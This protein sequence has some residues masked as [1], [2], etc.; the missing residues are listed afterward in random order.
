MSAPSPTPE[1]SPIDPKL[2]G[3]RAR[4]RELGSVLV[5]YSGGVDSAFVLAVAHQEL[6]PRAVGMTAVSPS[7][8]PAEKEEAT[9]IARDAWSDGDD[10]DQTQFEDNARQRYREDPFANLGPFREEYLHDVQDQQFY[11]VVEVELDSL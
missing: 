3:L 8:A 9:A 1:G 4:L 7:L 5:C 2:A 11:E 10:D 6:G